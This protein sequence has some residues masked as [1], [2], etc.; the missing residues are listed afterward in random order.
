MQEAYMTPNHAKTS[1]QLPFDVVGAGLAP[2]SWVVPALVA[3][4]IRGGRRPWQRHIFLLTIVVYTTI[5]T[6]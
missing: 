4:A 2:A 6:P 3:A 5:I 1:P